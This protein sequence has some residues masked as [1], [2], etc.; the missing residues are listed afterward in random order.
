MVLESKGF[1]PDR[2]VAA[3]IIKVSDPYTGFC[4]ILDKFFN[5]ARHKTGI[6]QPSYISEGARV[7]ADVYLGAFAYIGKNCVI[8]NNVKIYPNAYIGDNVQ[9]GDDTIIY[10]GVK[11]YNDCLYR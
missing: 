9:V 8:G 5:N 6:E 11:I 4:N 3:T 10:A 2:P 7:G 1:T